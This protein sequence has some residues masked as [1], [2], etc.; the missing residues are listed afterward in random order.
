MRTTSKQC[1]YCTS[2]NYAIFISLSLRQQTMKRF[3]AFIMFGIDTY[4]RYSTMIKRIILAVALLLILFWPTT[5]VSFAQEAMQVMDVD[6]AHY[7]Q[8]AVTVEYANLDTKTIQ[9]LQI[10]ENGEPQTTNIAP[11]PPIHVG[12]LADIYLGLNANLAKHL[13]DA[14]DQLDAEQWQWSNIE[15]NLFVP[16]GDDGRMVTSPTDWTTQGWRVMSNEI[17][18]YFNA[19]HTKD[20]TFKPKFAKTPLKDLIVDTLQYYTSTVAQNNY[21]IVLTDGFD[22]TSKQTTDDIAAL[23][24]KNNVKIYLVNYDLPAIGDQAALLKELANHLQ[25]PIF[26]LKDKGLGPVW[27]QIAQQP[28]TSTLTYTTQQAPPFSISVQH[29][30][31]K[32]ASQ[33]VEAK[34]SPAKATIV[35]PQAGQPIT[36]TK[37]QVQLQLDWGNY[38]ARQIDEVIYSIAGS[39]PTKVTDFQVEHLSADS[40]RLLSFDVENI[41][42]GQPLLDIVIDEKIQDFRVVAQTR[43][44]TTFPPTPT[45]MNTPPPPTATSTSTPTP[46]PTTWLD[47]VII[48]AVT[49]IPEPIRNQILIDPNLRQLFS[50]FFPLAA[51]CALC[52]AI[53]AWRKAKRSNRIEVTTP[54]PFG[55]PTTRKTTE[56]PGGLSPIAQ[57]VLIQGERFLPAL[58]SLYEGRTK[59]GRDPSWADEY[60]PNRFVSL[61]QFAISISDDYRTIANYSQRNP[62]LI[63]NVK[64]IDGSEENL[65]TGSPLKS[66]SIIQFGPFKYKFQLTSQL[67]SSEY[68]TNG[69]V[70]A[71][72]GAPNA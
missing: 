44:N 41:P 43:L 50:L 64:A 65:E 9:E 58:I 26:D 36:T 10:F 13:T 71:K 3:S 5:P 56:V 57:L 25:T 1:A 21:L 49:Q 11:L 23:A 55:D 2:A 39:N 27:Q 45:A 67:G 69:R 22:K 4:H 38:P 16:S 46:T 17:A 42:E 12:I 52:L 60:L 70:V 72:A 29:G 31:V 37:T 8:M 32:S 53:I 63:D 51:L 61:Q 40:Q 48:P 28:L 19:Q 35:K 30:D 62:T 24:Q 47:S 15:R 20:A 34:I 33:A 6:L 18:L 54:L 14:V 66:G 59:F 68:H 7:P